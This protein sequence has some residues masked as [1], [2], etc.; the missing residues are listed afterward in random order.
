MGEKLGK[1]DADFVREHTGFV[2]GGIPPIGHKE[3][4]VT[5]ICFSMRKSGLRRDIRMPSFRSRRRS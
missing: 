1:A 5:L 3:P 2:I 4:M